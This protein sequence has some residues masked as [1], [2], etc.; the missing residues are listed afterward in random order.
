MAR[1]ASPVGFDRES[2]RGRESRT[3]LQTSRVLLI[4]YCLKY[5]GGGRLSRIG[6]STGREGQIETRFSSECVESRCLN[7]ERQ[8]EPEDYPYERRP[9][10]F[11]LEC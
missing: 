2:V 9:F 1:S 4:G 11:F 7:D 5:S 3:A 6:R 10:D 8:R